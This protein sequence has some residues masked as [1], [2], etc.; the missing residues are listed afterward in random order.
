MS[1]GTPEVNFPITSSEDYDDRWT[2]FEFAVMVFVY[3]SVLVF[4]VWCSSVFLMVIALFLKLMGFCHGGA[5]AEGG[6]ATESSGLLP[7][8]AED[9]DEF[10]GCTYAL[11]L[12]GFICA[13]VLVILM[14]V[15]ALVL[16]LL[17]F[18][19]GF[20]AAAVPETASE[21]SGLLPKDV[22]PVILYGAFEED[23][24]SGKCCRSSSSEDLYEGHD[25][26]RRSKDLSFLPMLYR[27]SIKIIGQTS[28]KYPTRKQRPRSFD[29]VKEWRNRVVRCGPPGLL[30]PSSFYGLC[31]PLKLESG[32]FMKM[33]GSV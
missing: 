4:F 26:R 3:T 22:A 5:V 12:N 17:G 29:P 25:Y 21:T 33:N 11:F 19:A 14:A 15:T 13:S 27:K 24:E 10:W 2:T 6:I 18:F 8:E 28:M 1:S 23:E 32:H 30:G 31:N 20:S 16:K 9:Q 7:K